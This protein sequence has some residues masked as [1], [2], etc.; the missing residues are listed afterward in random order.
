MAHQVGTGRGRTAKAR[1]RA[2]ASAASRR[3]ASLAAMIVAIV[4]LVLPRRWASSG[5]AQQVGT[6]RWRT[7]RAGARASASMEEN[8]DAHDEYSGDG[9]VGVAQKVGFVWVGPTGGHRA[10]ANG[11]GEGKGEGEGECH[12]G[13]E[14]RGL[15]R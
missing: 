10:M 11:E 15:P 14:L 12:C 1:A 6:G 13:G 3:M 9:D 2:R 7:A 4:L 8:G 5:L